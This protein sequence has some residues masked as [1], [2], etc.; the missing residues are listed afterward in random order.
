[1]P[2][3]C[4]LTCRRHANF[5]SSEKPGSSGACDVRL[6]HSR[7]RKVGRPQLR[8]VASTHLIRGRISGSTCA[9]SPARSARSAPI[10]RRCSMALPRDLVQFMLRTAILDRLSRAAVR[11]RCRSELRPGIACINR[12]T[13]VAARAPR[14]GRPVVSLPSAPCRI[15]EAEVESELGNEIPGLHQR[16]LVWYASQELWTDAV[17]HAIA[18]GDADQALGWIKNCA[19]ALVKRGDLF[20]LLAGNVYFHPWS[21][22]ANPKSGLRSRGGWPSPYVLTRRSSS[23]GEIERD[24][25][26]N[27]SPD[28]EVYSL[29]MRGDTLGCDRAKRR[30]RGVVVHRTRLSQPVSRSVDCKCCL[31]RRSFWPLETGD[32]KNFYAT[33]WI[34]Y[35]LDEDRRNVFAS[36]Y[37]RCIQGMAE[38][39]Q[40]RIAA[41]DRYYPRCTATRRTAR[42]P[43]F[44]RGGVARKPDRPHSIRAGSSWTRQRPC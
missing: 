9:I 33:P 7:R 31:E 38:A 30:Q 42:R 34:P 43:E 40:L 36:V 39:Q 3:R 18:A 28:R 25:G 20:T 37:Y 5:S 29:R 15:F 17:Q 10:W 32:L 44:S 8:I 24:I 2:Q 23:L 19:M 12:E 21:C 41:A 14:S 35:S 16:A 22:G 13:S 26:T 27:P 6:L 11:G 1:M 4:D